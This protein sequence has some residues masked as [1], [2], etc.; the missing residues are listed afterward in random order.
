VSG[1]ALR[2]ACCDGDGERAETVLD[3]RG[4]L[5]ARMLTIS[6]IARA[7]WAPVF[8]NAAYFNGPLTMGCL[9]QASNFEANK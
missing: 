2:K 6:T 7:Q 1:R 8:R 3:A 4:V 9:N 5:R